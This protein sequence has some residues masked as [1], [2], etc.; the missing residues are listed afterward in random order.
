[1]KEAVIASSVRTAVG[2]AYKGTLHATRP[3]D[4]AA[5]AITAALQRV[6][7]EDEDVVHVRFLPSLQEP[8]ATVLGLAFKLRDP[9]H[10]IGTRDDIGITL[11]LVPTH[12]PGVEIGR[13]VVET[14][15]PASRRLEKAA[16]LLCK[17]RLRPRD[18]SKCPGKNE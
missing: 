3:D 17:S 5:V 16:R 18:G 11:A 14:H 8:V 9:D 13:P 6:R 7:R 1:M 12:L 15:S 10:L 4:L 2:K